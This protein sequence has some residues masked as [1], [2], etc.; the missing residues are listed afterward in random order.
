M[1]GV[2]FKVLDLPTSTHSLREG[3][4]AE[5]QTFSKSTSDYLNTKASLT[6]LNCSKVMTSPYKFFKIISMFKTN[7]LKLIIWPNLI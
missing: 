2:H 3:G 7:S 1:I 5:A 6:I 4:G